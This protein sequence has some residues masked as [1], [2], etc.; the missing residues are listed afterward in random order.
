M[1]VEARDNLGIRGPG[2]AIAGEHH[3]IDRRQRGRPVAETLPHEAPQSVAADGEAN[4]LPGD[5]EAESRMMNRVRQEE[6]REMPVDRPLALG[7]DTVELRL[8]QQAVLARERVP[9]GRGGTRR[10]VGRDRP[11]PG[12]A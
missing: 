3:D 1:P 2:G 11:G 6:N 4:L 7:E 8:V 9:L 12:Y 5:H 10:R